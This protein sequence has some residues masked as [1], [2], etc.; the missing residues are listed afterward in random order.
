MDNFQFQAGGGQAFGTA[1]ASGGTHVALAEACDVACDSPQASWGAWGG[2]VGA[3]GTVAGNANS[4]GITYTLG[5]FAAGLDRRLGNNFLLGVATGFTAASLYSQAVPGTGTSNIFQV[6]LYGEWADGPVYLDALAGYARSDNRMTRPIVIPGLPY[7]AAQGQTT[8][9]QFFGQ[10][11][12]GYKVGL[13]WSNSFVTPF[14]RLQASTSTQAGFTES[15]ADSLN[16]TVASQTTQSLRSVLGAQFATSIDAGWRDTLNLTFRLGWS[17]EFADLI[18]PVTASFA[19]APAAGFTTQGALAPRDG[20]IVGLAANTRV[21][22]ATS[23]YARYDGD[24]AG[25]NTGH[26][27]SAGVRIVW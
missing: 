17:H 14:A 8:A 3:F 5:G 27:L 7:R 26:I 4:S 15:G 20:A 24:I 11:E 18:R 22:D 25:A 6:G 9:D 23:L 16:L 19:G 21:G 13:G 1:N 12:G 10:L 2:G